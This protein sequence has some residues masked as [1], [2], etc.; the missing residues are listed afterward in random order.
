MRIS[1]TQRASTR[2][3]AVCSERHART[4]PKTPCTIMQADSL[5]MR[6]PVPSIMGLAYIHRPRPDSSTAQGMNDNRQSRRKCIIIQCIRSP[7]PLI[8]CSV[9]GKVTVTKGCRSYVRPYNTL[10][11][12]TLRHRGFHH[13]SVTIVAPPW[14]LHQAKPGLAYGRCTSLHR[15]RVSRLSVHTA[16]RAPDCPTALTTQC[17][18]KQV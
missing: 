7:I 1:S 18:A 16:C 8:R 2:T 4:T 14:T 11:T 12:H 6:C 10:R 3:R 17:L 15:S 13:E 5:S 9:E